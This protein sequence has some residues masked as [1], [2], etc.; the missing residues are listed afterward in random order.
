[1]KFKLIY[2]LPVLAALSFINCESPLPDDQLICTNFSTFN[3]LDPDGNPI[4]NVDDLFLCGTGQDELDIKITQAQSDF[5]AAVQEA[6]EIA[7][8]TPPVTEL[9]LLD[10]DAADSPPQFFPFNDVEG[11]LV[12]NPFLSGA[13]PESSLVLEIDDSGNQ[14]FGGVAIPLNE[15]VDFTGNSSR[16]ILLDFYSEIPVQNNVELQVISNVDGAQV[17]DPR[18]SALK[19]SHNGSGWETLTFNYNEGNGAVTSFINGATDNG[20][21]IVPTGLFNQL[22]LI[23]N[24]GDR[25]SGPFYVDNIRFIVGDSNEEI[26]EEVIEEEVV[27][28]EE[29]VE[30]IEMPATVFEFRG[31]P[32]EYQ[33]FNGAAITVVENPFNS[34]SNV[35]TGAVLQV[36]NF[37]VTNFEGVASDLLPSEIDFSSSSNKTLT[38]DVY[39]TSPVNVDLQVKR[40]MAGATEDDDNT[41][42]ADPRSASLTVTHGGTGWET[43]T[44]DY[45]NGAIRAFDNFADDGEPFVPEGQFNQVVF[46]IDSGAPAPGGEAV[47]FVDN[48]AFEPSDIVEEPVIVEEPLAPVT[49]SVIE[50]DEAGLDFVSNSFSFGDIASINILNNPVPGGTN[51]D[52]TNVFE[53]VVDTTLGNGFNGFGFD[54]EA[55]GLEVLDFT[56]DNKLITISVYSEVAFTLQVQVGN[57]RDDAGVDIIEPRPANTTA[58]HSGSGWEDLV[59]DF[60]MSPLFNPFSNNPDAPAGGSEIPEEELGEIS[61]T[62]NSLQFQFNGAPQA[63]M[64]TFYIDNIRYNQ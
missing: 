55:F 4:S 40:L 19:V 57:G 52:V 26:E 43:L 17:T 23:S 14:D 5:D 8:S 32:V 58:M 34:G 48:I 35:E 41:L 62:Y 15:E 16:T 9:V 10:F 3:R 47:Y 61:G 44:F 50:F 11:A 56:G 59:F 30:E 25:V 33:G 18:G 64:S 45:N 22:V 53:A 1:M 38:M 51:P 24:G 12:T 28:E 21:P 54:I 27:V 20:Q 60:S 6:R 46:L 2:S 39:S 13:N 63:A 42:L 36:T 31:A 29:V 37:A 7:A 49:G